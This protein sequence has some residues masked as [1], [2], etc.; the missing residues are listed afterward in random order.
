[1]SKHTQKPRGPWNKDAISRLILYARKNDG[2][3]DDPEI[4]CPCVEQYMPEE[5]DAILIAESPN[6]I[7][8]LDNLILACQLPGDHCEIEQAIAAAIAAIARAKWE[9]HD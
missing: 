2:P 7:E 8:A 5:E 6:L 1:M 9:P 4:W 3:W